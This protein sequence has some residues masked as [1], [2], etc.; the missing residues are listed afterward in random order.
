[1][2]ILEGEATAVIGEE[3]FDLGPGDATWAP[4]GVPH[5]FANRGEGPMRMYWVYGVREVTRTICATGVTVEHLSDE[6]RGAEVAG[7]SPRAAITE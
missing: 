5:R 1:M 2:V 3:S 4:A 7:P 6:D